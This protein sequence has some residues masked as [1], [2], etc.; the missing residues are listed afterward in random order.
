MEDKYVEIKFDQ[1]WSEESIC[2]FASFLAKMQG[3]DGVITK[4]EY[5]DGTFCMK[6]C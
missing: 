2:Q 3:I 5:D 4:T 6:V 1:N